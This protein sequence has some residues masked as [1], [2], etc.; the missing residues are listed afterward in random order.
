MP[1]STNIEFMHLGGAI[2]D[3][4]KD[5]TA[6]YFREASFELHSITN[7]KEEKTDEEIEEIRY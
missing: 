2:R 3:T 4:P 7:W 6:F 5:S 1:P